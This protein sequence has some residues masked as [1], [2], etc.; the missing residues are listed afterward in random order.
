MPALLPLRFFSQLLFRCVV[1]AVVAGSGASEA[2]G[3]LWVYEGFQYLGGTDLQDN[4]LNP[5][6]PTLAKGFSSAWTSSDAGEL[7]KIHNTGLQYGALTTRGLSLRS[8][9]PP[10]THESGWSSLSAQNRR[11]LQATSFPPFASI[12]EIWI[13]YLIRR[14]SAIWNGTV[15]VFTDYALLNIITSGGSPT[16]PALRIGE[17][18]GG[19]KL[20]FAILN[21][22]EGAPVNGGPLS[23][24][25][26]DTKLVVFKMTINAGAADFGELFVNPTIGQSTPGVN[27]VALGDINVPRLFTS[28]DFRTGN[29]G[30]DFTFDELRIGSTYADVTPTPEP[31]ALLLL[32]TGAVLAGAGRRRRGTE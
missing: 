6:D 12:T 25:V 19:D 28:L 4:T 31:T 14:D 27:P 16:V 9:T 22:A 2:R 5:D 10:S 15:D 21:G 24:S 7:D 8:Y 29:S 3:E 32:A 18:A 11:T 26:G 23:L 1:A 17:L 20:G 30:T 13:S